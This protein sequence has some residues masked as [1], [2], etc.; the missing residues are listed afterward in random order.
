MSRFVLVSV[1]CVLIS[2]CQAPSRISDPVVPAQPSITDVK[3]GFGPEVSTEDLSMH[4]KVLASDEFGGRAPGTEGEE[5]TVAYL[6]QQF[7]RLG[8]KPGNGDSYVQTVPIES[9]VGPIR[10]TITQ[11]GAM[12]LSDGQEMVLHRSEL[13]T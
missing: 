3:H 2:A 12:V 11:T 9:L 7:Q 6:I 1:V 4:I 8:L 5:K 10:H 13:P